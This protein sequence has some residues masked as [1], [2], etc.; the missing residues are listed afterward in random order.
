LHTFR[1]VFIEVFD[2]LSEQEAYTVAETYGTGVDKK[3]LAIMLVLV[4]SFAL[5]GSFA[6]VYFDL[7]ADF[8]SLQGNYANL[9][10]Q[11]DELQSLIQA[12]KVNE[13][14]GL[15]AVQIYNRTKNSVV[16]ISAGGK[17][18]SGFVY[19]EAGYIVTN[20]HVVDGSESIITVTFLNGT[21][22]EA[23]F[24][25][26]DVYT[27]LSVLRIDKNK[28]PLDAVPLL[29]GNSTQ[30]MVGEPVYAIGNPFG[31]SSS[32]TAGIASQLGRVLRLGDL[33][34]PEPW[35]SY[36]IVDVIQFDA[37]VNPGNSGG[38]LLDSVG[39]VVGI[40]F[41][42]ETA[43]NISGFIGIGYAV[44]ESLV[45]RV[46]PAI[47]ENGTYKHPWLGVSYDP[48]YI[49]GLKIET[50]NSS[51]PAD[52]AGLQPGDVI[53][54]VDGLSV[55]RAEDLVIYLERYKS[56]HDVINV[57]IAGN[58]TSIQLTLGERS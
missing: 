15:A 27:D 47:I 3:L 10:A 7:K 4:V 41:A 6:L 50:I 45:H 44:P 16:V 22:A 23:Q 40:T 38:P 20:N 49:G 8:D 46:V 48:T 54:E 31:L 25:G 30:M 29:L 56:P 52:V 33:G 58:D 55:K 28:L 1:L 51:G 9:S 57:K 13:T 36:S 14:S 21:V 17:T 39:F 32:M 11:I 53:V 26:G 35:G 24:I 34:V 42:I 18:G 5:I 19:D 2:C 12:L 43:G 37:A